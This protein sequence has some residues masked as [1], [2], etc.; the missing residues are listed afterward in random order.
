MN[1]NDKQS[2]VEWLNAWGEKMRPGI[3]Q[4]AIDGTAMCYGIALSQGDVEGCRNLAAAW[5]MLT[6]GR[7]VEKLH[8]GVDGLSFEE[9]CR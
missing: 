1:V 5:H 8:H 7:I 3:L 9:I 2:A 4:S 6:G